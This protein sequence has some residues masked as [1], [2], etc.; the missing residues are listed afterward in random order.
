MVKYNEIINKHAMNIIYTS[1]ITVVLMIILFIILKALPINLISNN[2]EIGLF[3]G[4]GSLIT[5]APMC[6]WIGLVATNTLTCSCDK[7]NDEPSNE[8]TV[9]PTQ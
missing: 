6:V 3:I 4:I 9:E 7:S 1:I 2:Q 8:P 5:I